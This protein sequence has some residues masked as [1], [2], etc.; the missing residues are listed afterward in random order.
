MAPREL[1]SHAIRSQVDVRLDL[2][3]LV[4]VFV[5]RRL[6]VEVAVPTEAEVVIVGQGTS[7]AWAPSIRSAIRRALGL[8][9]RGYAVSIT[10]GDGTSRAWAPPTWRDRLL[11]RWKRSPRRPLSEDTPPGYFANKADPFPKDP[12]EHWRRIIDDLRDQAEGPPRPLK[13]E[14]TP[15]PWRKP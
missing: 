3:D 10:T 7:R 5:F 4:R 2:R 12:P 6:T 14:P 9:P 13:I 11:A 15:D 1:T 8:R